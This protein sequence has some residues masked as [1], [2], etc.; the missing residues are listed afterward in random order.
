MIQPGVY[1]IKL[2]RRADYSVQL[3]FKDSNRD[4][5]N[6]TGWTVAAQVWDPSRTTKY[7]DFSVTYTDR[8]AGKVK[9]F[10]PFNI[11][12]DL[13]SQS[14]YDVLLINPAGIREYYV[15]GSVDALEGYTAVP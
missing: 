13:P 12:T 15:E 3:E 7:A 4:P 2:Q 9:L 6:L 5:I 10:L 8:N 1:N 14:V 11:T